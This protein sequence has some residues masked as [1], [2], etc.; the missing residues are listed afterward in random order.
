MANIRSLPSG[1]WNAQVRLK[2]KPAQSKTFPT[3]VEARAW[4]DQLEAVT[5]QHKQHTIYTL[6]MTYCESLLKGKGS[7]AHAIQIV[8]QLAHAFPKLIHQ[9]TP[10]K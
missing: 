5:K 1:N 9:I 6:G 7:Y 8:E 4:A 10:K 2:G 3:E